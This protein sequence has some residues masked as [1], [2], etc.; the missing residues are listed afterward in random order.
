MKKTLNLL[1]I[2]IAIMGMLAL[3]AIQHVII[4]SA[5]NIAMGALLM[6]E[7]LTGMALLIASEN[8]AGKYEFW[9]KLAGIILGALPGASLFIGLV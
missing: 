3:S 1:I 6:A 9:L 2:A 7:M 5:P 8:G 4:C